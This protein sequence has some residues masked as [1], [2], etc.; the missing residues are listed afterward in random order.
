MATAQQLAEHADCMDK[1]GEFERIPEVGEVCTGCGR[2]LDEADEAQQPPW[3]AAEEEHRQQDGLSP[4]GHQAPPGP[5]DPPKAPKGPAPGAPRPAPAEPEP[6]EKAPARR[7]AQTIVAQPEDPIT[8]SV[9]IIEP[10]HVY[11][12]D[13]INSHIADCNARIERGANFHRLCI[14]EKFRTAME[15]K[16]AHA[17]ALRE[18]RASTVAER[19][20]E[21]VLAC[22]EAYRAMNDALMRERAVAATMHDVRALLS[23]YQSVA[24]SVGVTYS[25]AGQAYGRNHA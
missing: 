24:R 5:Y 6:A 20:A 4:M 12:P 9:E 11:T 17:R 23:G 13:E 10:G 2:V 1:G 19:E 18:A 14:E 22:E 8:T 25:A 7:S 3:S 21:A 15:Y 16:F